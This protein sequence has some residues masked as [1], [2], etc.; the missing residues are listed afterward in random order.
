MNKAY[1][2]FLFL[3]LVPVVASQAQGTVPSNL[4]EP[5]KGYRGAVELGFLYQKP[6]TIN[7]FNTNYS[8]VSN[9]TLSLFNGYAVHRLFAMGVTVGADFYNDV[10]VTPLAIGLRGTFFNSKVSP[11]YSLDTGYGFTMLSEES[12]NLKNDG[13]WMFNPGIGLKVKAGNNTAFLVHTGYKMQRVE[14]EINQWGATVHQK[15][16]FKRLS[17]RI[18]FEF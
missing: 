13:G 2:I 14:T 4:E 1:I 12:S 16:T 6:R 8:S 15:T 18:G 3:L 11:Y 17:L 7:N 9:P 5:Q 10:L